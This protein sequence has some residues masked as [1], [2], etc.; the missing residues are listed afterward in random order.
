MGGP[1]A[2]YVEGM[3]HLDVVVLGAGSAGEVAAQALAKGGRSVAVVEGGRVGGGCPYVACVPSKSL[4]HSAASLPRGLT[5]DEASAAYREAVRRRDEAAVHLDDS[6]ASAAL[7]ASGA[8]VV[9][10]SARV[11]A[12][13][14]VVVGDET[15]GWTDLVVA[16]GSEPVVPDLPG[17]DRVPTWTSDEALTS[18]ELPPS[19]VVLGGGAVG[20][21]LAQVF[22]RFGV[23]VTVVEAAAQLLGDEHPA[24]SS[25]LRDA[26]VRDG[27]DVRLSVKAERFEHHD[28]GGAR[29]LLSDGSDVE[30][31]RVLVAVGRRPRLAGLGLEAL[32]ITPLDGALIV[33][34]R[35]RAV[36]QEHVWAAGDVTAVAAFTHTAKYQAEVVAAN[37]LGVDRLARYDGVPRAVYTDPPVVSVGRTDDGAGLVSAT[38]DLAELGRNHTDAGSGG[39]LVATAD[40]SSGTLVGAA[41]IGAR[42]DDWMAEA[43]LAVRAA[44]PLHVLVDTVHAFPTMSEAFAPVYRELVARC[45]GR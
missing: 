21:E 16:T 42:A 4:L 6:A 13:G 11:T 9:R 38:F 2:G 7:E 33:D 26:L 23:Q 39:L 12:P 28:G 27:V 30:C 29:V 18:S 45:S 25:L 32:E 43:V 10:G 3:A 24:V 14:V 1:C 44:V 5:A 17:L 19:L 22:A 37:I 8:R 34:D 35:C 36:G 40:P 41:T 31:A 20:C 15:L